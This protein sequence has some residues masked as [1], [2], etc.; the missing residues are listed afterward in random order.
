MPEQ[1]YEEQLK[2]ANEAVYKH[3][4][5]LARLKQE[6]ELTNQR[7][8][9]LIH[10]IGHEV[11]GFLTKDMGAFAALSEGDFGPLPD[12]MKPF[13]ESA[14]ANAREG[15]ASVMD[16]LQASNLKKGTVSYKKEPFD[17]K[18]LVE[19][20]FGKL[21]EL[22]EQKGLKFNLSV[23]AAGEPYTMTGDHNQLG[24]HVLRNIIENSINY[25]PSGT[26]DVSLTKQGDK[27]VFAVKDTGVGIS[28]EDRK[29]LFTEGGKGKDS[30]KVNTR[31][32]GYVLFIAK[33]IVEAHGGT[34]RAGSDGAGKGAQFVVELPAA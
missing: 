34:I 8:E 12:G 26:I 18:A 24:E 6:L 23:D 19:E 16:I 27:F 31:S 25:T 10:F 2:A 22:A 33:S 30:L 11:K 15:A 13:V 3:S 14:L 4:L 21:K 9:S 28:D 29:H 5:E 17:L 1:T 7:Q 32:T 20:R